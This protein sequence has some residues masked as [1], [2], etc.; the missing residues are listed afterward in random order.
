[1]K[2]ELICVNHFI[3]E[4]ARDKFMYLI[5]KDLQKV[6]SWFLFSYVFI[7]LSLGACSN[8][9]KILKGSDYEKKYSLAVKLYEKKDFQRAYPLFEELVSVTRATAKAEDVYYYYTWCDYYLDDL[10]SAAYHFEQFEEMFPSSSR[11]EEMA[12]MVAFCYF[13]GSPEYS[14]DQT[15]S[16][17]AIEQFQL[18][19]NKYPFSSR[20]Q[21][22]NELI[23]KLR[24]K[25]EKKS[26]ETGM[27][28]FKTN[29]FKAAIISLNNTLRDYPTTNYKE[30]ILFTILKSN[31]LLAENSVES[32]KIERYNQT[33]TAY[34]SFIDK[35]AKSKFADEANSIKNKASE[36]IK[37]LT[38]SLNPF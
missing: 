21:E 36:Q 9:Q 16:L 7:I 12:F 5:L 15:N 35:F 18:F 28:F 2:T 26:F 32:K 33:L 25:M 20:I 6:R 29:D 11:T 38:T 19:V 4:P 13:R 34:S 37:Q 1:M 22:C 30:I 8:Y 17:K 3:Q 10:V 27:L 31:F 23:D 24:A 14:L